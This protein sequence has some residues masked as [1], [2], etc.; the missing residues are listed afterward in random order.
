MIFINLAVTT[1]L[2]ISLCAIF[3]YHNLSEALCSCKV[4]GVSSVSFYNGILIQQAF[5]KIDR[6]NRPPEALIEIT[7]RHGR[8]P[9]NLL[10]IFRTPFFMKTS[11]GL[12]L[13]LCSKIILLVRFIARS[14]FGFSVGPDI[15]LFPQY[16][17]RLYF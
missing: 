17:L 1:F 11:R 12:P 5:F 15:K 4:M 7:L 16:K 3:I 9:V 8:S 14:V 2:S 10:H 13:N 6:N